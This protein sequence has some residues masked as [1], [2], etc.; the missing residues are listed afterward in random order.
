[1]PKVSVNKGVKFYIKIPN[2]CREN[3]EKL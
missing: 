1:M 2:G 3:G